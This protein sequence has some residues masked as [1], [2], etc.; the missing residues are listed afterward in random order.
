M[1]K[2]K[3]KEIETEIVPLLEQYPFTRNDDKILYLLLLEKKGYDLNITLK[4]YLSAMGDNYPNY[5]S[6]TRCRRKIQEKRPDLIGNRRI[7]KL[8]AENES[9][10]RDY[11]IGSNTGD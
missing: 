9:E 11:A 10:Y 2:K 1:T 5:D 6:V 3:L 8:R 4:D 7:R